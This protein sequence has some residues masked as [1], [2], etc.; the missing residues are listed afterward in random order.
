MKPTIVGLVVLGLF[1][2]VPVGV[3]AVTAVST[4]TVIPTLEV[5]LTPTIQP[6][7]DLSPTVGVTAINDD[8]QDNLAIWFL[9][10]TVGLLLI[11]IVAQAWPKKDEEDQ[12]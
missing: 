12:S 11:I 2:C 4:E 8:D 7:I 9:A 5:T 3:Q 10:A 6:T 1:V